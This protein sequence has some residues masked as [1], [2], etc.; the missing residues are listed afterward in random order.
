MASCRNRLFAG[1]LASIRAGSLFALLAAGLHPLRSQE[2]GVVAVLCPEGPVCTEDA[3]EIVFESGTS[4]YAGPLE[5]G[6]EI[7]VGVVMDAR[8]P[9]IQGFSYAVK[10]DPEF[11]SLIPESVTTA[12][13][14]L[15]PAS[16]G[17]VMA[18][19][20]FD[21]TR[22]VPGGFISA[23]VLA[24]YESRE[25]PPGRNV[26]CHAAYRVIAKP[27]C[28]IIRIVDHQLR[29][30]GS[31]PVAV[32]IT[33]YGRSRQPRILRQGVIGDGTC[34]ETCDDHAD[35]DGNGLADCMDPECPFLRCNGEEICDDGIDNDLNGLV[36]CEED[37]CFGKDPACPGPELC[38]DGIDNDGD[39]VLDC[40]DVECALSFSCR[41]NCRNGKDDDGDAL[42]DCHDRDC[43][44][45]E[46]CDVPETCGD[47]L[48]NDWDSLVDCDDRDCAGSPSCPWLEECQDAEDNDGD[49]LVDC[50]D[51]DCSRD[52]L[53]TDCDGDGIPDARDG[54]CTAYSEG[55]APIAAPF[56]R[57]DADGNLRVDIRDVLLIIDAATGG[58][59][60]VSCLAALNTNADEGVTLAD[61]SPLLGWIFLHGPPLPAPF[62]EC[63]T[64]PDGGCHA[65]GGC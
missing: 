32:N 43:R 37:S 25:M 51:S 5:I 17:S 55:P 38:W 12:G 34:K 9:G 64:L 35:N 36:D 56:I 40:E 58:E 18:A 45:D 53:C 19:S 2:G 26:I 20:H 11:L 8:S 63:G 14:I 47:G 61:V 24:L 31:P 65:P 60:P 52:E 46:P 33:A 59:R 1:C 3:L 49:G 44:W 13:T 23:V 16:P 54:I 48:D 27:E 15:D 57:G 10:H 39:G 7:P 21:A 50:A 42:I 28:S 62:P 6:T 41:E 22:P 4:T 29:A 30:P